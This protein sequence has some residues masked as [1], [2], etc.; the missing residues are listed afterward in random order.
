MENIVMS[1]QLRCRTN[2]VT[3]AS[4]GEELRLAQFLDW[5]EVGKRSGVDAYVRRP[6]GHMADHGRMTEAFALEERQ[7]VIHRGFVA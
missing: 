5:K 3:E 2:A 1:W 4:E 7:H 6:F